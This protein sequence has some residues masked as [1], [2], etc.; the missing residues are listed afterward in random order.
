MV[1]LKLGSVMS[2]YMVIG[3]ILIVLLFIHPLKMMFGRERPVKISS[4]KRICNMRDKEHHKSMPSGDAMVCG[5]FIGMYYY[6]FSASIFVFM[7]L[8]LIAAGRVYTHCH[9]IG[10]TVV[11]G[12]A[13]II[14]SYFMYSPEYFEVLAK[15]FYFAVFN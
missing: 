3:I 12:A 6:A 7:F 15:P 4:V 2:L 9:W 14:G 8:P 11:G 13:G 5:V 10:D 1:K